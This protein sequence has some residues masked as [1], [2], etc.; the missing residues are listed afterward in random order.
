MSKT[1]LMD[2]QSK[3]FT[4]FRG[5]KGK[6]SGLENIGAG[7][8]FTNC[9]LEA[10][11]H[12][13]QVYSCQ[14]MVD[15]PLIIDVFGNDCHFSSYDRISIG[16]CSIVPESFRRELL[17]YQQEY[18]AS[19]VSV[20]DIVSI[21]A[22]S[23]KFDSVIVKNVIEGCTN[24]PIYDVIV[25]DAN[26]IADCKLVDPSND[27]YNVWTFKRINLAE[28]INEDEHDNYAKI[29]RFPNYNIEYPFIKPTIIE[30]EL[31]R[32]ITISSTDSITVKQDNKYLKASRLCGENEY[33]FEGMK[34]VPCVFDPI[35]GM[36]RICDFYETIDINRELSIIHI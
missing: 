27:D 25:F 22:K 5:S 20:D 12:S 11:G 32:I 28:Y 17:D 4:F 31:K 33:L 29:I 19:E 18:E 30:T 14:I 1:L 21:A 3:P 15:S 34:Q 36:V 9:I 26:C 16:N 7:C 10:N 35:N 23:M 13:A 6:D 8:Y 24:I 2:L